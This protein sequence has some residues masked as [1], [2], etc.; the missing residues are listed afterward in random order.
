MALR[1]LLSGWLIAVAA[2]ARSMALVLERAAADR[3]EPTPNSVP[4]PVMAAL[5]ER[6]PG[7]PDHWLALVAERTSQL[8]DVGEAPLSL[9]SQ[10]SAWPSSLPG[11]TGPL[12]P[13]L[14]TSPAGDAA[15]PREPPR[16]VVNPT[17]R[18]APESDAVPSLSALQGRSSEVWRRPQV[19]QGRRPR[20][21][22]A[23]IE[24]A[25]SRPAS[26]SE[27]D[28]PTGR[29]PR[30]P[31]TLEARPPA[32]PPADPR[33]PVAPS[34][35]SV[36]RARVWSDVKPPGVEEQPE[37]ALAWL[38]PQPLE[39]E[40]AAGPEAVRRPEP[41][42]PQGEPQEGPPIGRS[43]SRSLF[44]E[45][46]ATAS[47]VRGASAFQ[48]PVDAP[49]R[50]A[51]PPSPD[52]PIVLDAATPEGP[53]FT[54]SPARSTV[55]RSIFK[56]LAGLRD[57]ARVS[58]GHHHQAAMKPAPPGPASLGDMVSPADRGAR[59]FVPRPDLSQPATA[60]PP[61]PHVRVS[62]GDDPPTRA[63]RQAVAAPTPRAPRPTWAPSFAAG[64]FANDEAPRD[65]RADFAISR[66]PSARVSA[67]RTTGSSVDDRW[68]KFPPNVF[69]PPLVAEIP[70]PRLDQLAREQE[71]GRWSV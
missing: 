4:G 46:S 25:P 70:A 32:D 8:A 23:P 17:P 39:P 28:A 29:R 37:K 30:S 47:A 38:P 54:P 55:R 19:A 34:S 9:S 10:P 15:P 67:P 24:P 5:A 49:P 57:R 31:L 21:V 12:A 63:A 13:L 16:A 58:S 40:R 26:T 43:A 65:P 2:L 27:G 64:A 52:R 45:T 1:R 50:R 68:P 53:A 48:S 3:S 14:Q 22:F 35:K 61:A 71:E 6:Y 42:E 51:A 44:A 41:G 18:P 20:P 7:A 33:G 56:A 59:S 69:A 36:V 66:P 62:E 60:A 11:A